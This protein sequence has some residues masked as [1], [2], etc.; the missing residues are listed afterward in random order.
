MQ[1]PKS[2]GT[3]TLYISIWLNL[4]NHER[5]PIENAPDLLSM[6]NESRVIIDYLRFNVD[7]LQPWLTPWLH[8]VITS[9]SSL[10]K[11]SNHGSVFVKIEISIKYIL[12]GLILWKSFSNVFDLVGL[13]HT[14]QMQMCSNVLQ[15]YSILQHNL[16]HCWCWEAMPWPDWNYYKIIHLQTRHAPTVMRLE[17]ANWLCRCG[18]T[19]QHT[20]LSLKWVGAG[21]STRRQFACRKS[22]NRHKRS[23]EHLRKFLEC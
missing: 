22:L 8:T 16:Y 3:D 9:N 11:K 6:L 23:K 5:V 17:H 15:Y 4:E 12:I 14:S 20:A 1:Q 13:S 18:G 21:W 7:G 10:I 19:R 2:W